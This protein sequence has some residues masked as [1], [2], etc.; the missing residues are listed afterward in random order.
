MA[1][2]WY[3]TAV[4]E[5]LT[6]LTAGYNQEEVWSL[7]ESKIHTLKEDVISNNHAYI[8]FMV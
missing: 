3:Q 7:R 2:G 8:S 1:S 4:N 5:N 6:K